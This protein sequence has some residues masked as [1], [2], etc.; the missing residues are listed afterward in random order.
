[1]RHRLFRATAALPL[2]FVVA[3]LVGGAALGATGR[4]PHACEDHACFCRKP[5]GGAPKAPCH[6]GA[7]DGA[8]RMVPACDHDA[9]P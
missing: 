9:D 1:M 2:V 4:D 8:A 5:A 7:D 3:Q 6:G